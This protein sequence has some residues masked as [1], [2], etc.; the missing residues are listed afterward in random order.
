MKVIFKSLLLIILV[1]FDVQAMSS[2]PEILE[3]EIP[4]IN[5]V[6]LEVDRSGEIIKQVKKEEIFDTTKP[7]TRWRFDFDLEEDPEEIEADPGFIQK[8]VEF[9][10]FLIEMSLWLAIPIII[11]VL[12]RY[13]AY[14]RNL[15]GSDHSTRSGKEIPDLVFGLDI[16]KEALPEDIEAVALKYWQQ[17]KYRQA[18]SLLYRGA[19]SSLFREHHLELSPGATEQDCIRQVRALKPGELSRHFEE[20][21]T[22][23]SI[24]AY[25]HRQPDELKFTELSTQWHEHYGSR[26]D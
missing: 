11:F 16:R 10:S 3:A 1:H 26:H 6:L 21:T 14:W 4:E 15:L 9:I 5:P 23:W 24:V 8:F 19:L 13:R 7:V 18:V 2:E 20:L 12:Y 22:T 17:N 25:A